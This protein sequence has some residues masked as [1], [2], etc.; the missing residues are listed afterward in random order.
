[1]ATTPRRASIDIGS[2]TIRVLVAAGEGPGLQR[3]EVRRRITRLSGGFDG[4]LSD[5]AMQRTLE[6]AGEFAAFAREQGAEQIRIGCT[7]VVRRAENRDDFLWEVEKVTDVPPVLLS[8]EVEADLAGRGA[9]HHLGPTTP[10]LVLVDVG[11]F[12]TELSIVGEHTSHIAS[13]DLGVVR[14]TE[15]LLTGDPPSPEQLAAARRHCDDILGFYFQRPMPRLIAGIAGTPTT[16]A[17]VLQG[18]T[19]YDPAK[20]HRFAAGREA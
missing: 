17:A 2:N 1:M 10:E 19:V 6:A 7:G 4:N 16:I 20:V 9:R 8:G 15:D 13:F 14:L 3:L 18:L 5:A 12:S 11:G